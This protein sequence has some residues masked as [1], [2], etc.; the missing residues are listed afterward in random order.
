MRKVCHERHGVLE[1]TQHVFELVEKDKREWT[2]QRTEP[3][4]KKRREHITA[5]QIASICGDNP[6]ETR[7]TALKKKI[8]HEKPFTGNAATEWGNKYEDTAILK[9]E[10]LTGR[11][12][13]EF[14]LLESLNEGEDYLAGSPDGITACGVLIEVKCPFRRK[15]KQGVVPGHYMHQL[16]TLMHI[17][18]LDAADF[19]EFVPGNT[20]SEETFIV[21]RVE[22]C[23]KFWARCEPKLRSFWDDVLAYRENGQL[24]RPLVEE[25]QKPKRKP[26]VITIGESE[27]PA[28]GCLIK[29]DENWAL[30]HAFL[31]NLEIMA[32]MNEIGDDFVE[33]EKKCIIEF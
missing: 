24:P 29:I 21:T 33:V 16:Q 19:V 5:S 26:R 3:W 13:L 30:P 28:A 6:Y 1:V 10:E 22:K 20:W 25:K 15:P 23:D 11:K 31:H 4:Y 32:A 2:P 14:G 18:R 9:Y 7:M 12:V 17:L 8:G 27:P